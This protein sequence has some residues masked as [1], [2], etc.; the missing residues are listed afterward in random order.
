LRLLLLNSHCNIYTLCI[1]IVTL[2]Y[3]VS[4]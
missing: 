1:H 4:C 3:L 2:A